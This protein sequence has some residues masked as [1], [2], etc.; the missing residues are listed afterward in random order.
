MKL[1]TIDFSKCGNTFQAAR[2]TE[3]AVSA[4][5]QVIEEEGFSPAEVFSLCILMT[6][7]MSR[8]MP[9]AADASRLLQYAH[10]KAM[11]ILKTLDRTRGEPS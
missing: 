5:K 1:P 8:A 6:N 11:W 10:E 9:V 7:M 4:L 3:R 2:V